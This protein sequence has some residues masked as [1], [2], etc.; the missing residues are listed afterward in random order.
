MPTAKLE[1]TSFGLGFAE[2]GTAGSLVAVSIVAVEAWASFRVAFANTRV[3]LRV[4]FVVELASAGCK[5]IWIQF[6]HF[7]T[8]HVLGQNSWE[9]TIAT[10]VTGVGVTDT[11]IKG[12][13]V[14]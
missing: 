13:V 5:A 9:G 14:A 12:T 11:V 8:K 2:V 7:G 1:S 10:P 6:A 4:A 3:I